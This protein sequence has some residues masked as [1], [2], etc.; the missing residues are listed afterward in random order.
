MRIRVSHTR[1]HVMVEV[2]DEHNIPDPTRRTTWDCLSDEEAF[3]G[4][5]IATHCLELGGFKV[6]EPPQS[7]IGGG[8]TC[9]M[10]R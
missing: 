1:K 5:S 9:I 6:V 2:V 8:V 7:N 3:A 10:Q 4:F